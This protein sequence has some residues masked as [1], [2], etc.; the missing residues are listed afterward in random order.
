MKRGAKGI[1][2]NDQRRGFWYEMKHLVGVC[3]YIVQRHSWVGWD[4][5]PLFCFAWVYKCLLVGN[6]GKSM[7]FASIRT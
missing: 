4:Y 2:D 6:P 7:P 5:G 3:M 1:R